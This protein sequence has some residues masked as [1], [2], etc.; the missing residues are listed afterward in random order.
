MKLRVLLV[1]VMTILAHPA[2]AVDRPEA[3][4]SSILAADFG[5]NDLG[6]RD[7]VFYTDGKGPEVGDCGCTEPRENFYVNDD[8]IIVVADWQIGE[9]RRSGKAAVVTARFHVL[10]TPVMSRDVNASGAWSEVRIFV[11]ATPPREELVS[12]RLRLRHGHWILLDPPPPR[13]DIHVAIREL[14]KEIALE[15]ELMGKYPQTDPGWSGWKIWRDRY[16][17]QVSVLEPLLP[18]DQVI[19]PP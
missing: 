16:Q 11:A 5:G 4:L 2:L 15:E 12:Y 6:R 10:A 17:E 14:R 18:V 9:I 7:K 19:P 3:F 13:I 1:G 8:E